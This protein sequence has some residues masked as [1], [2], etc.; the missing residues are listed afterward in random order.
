MLITTLTK[1]NNNREC[2]VDG[3]KNQNDGNFKLTLEFGETNATF[4]FASTDCDHALVVC[5]LAHILA[6]GQPH[7]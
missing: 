3:S 5:D 2:I 6:E 4:R 7:I 1:H